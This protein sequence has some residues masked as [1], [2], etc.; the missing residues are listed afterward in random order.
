MDDAIM[1]AIYG[2]RGMGKSS[3]AKQMMANY[4]RAVVLD[5]QGEFAY[6]PGFKSVAWADIP[7]AINQPKFNLSYKPKRGAAP[8][9]LHHI[10]DLL[11][12]HQQP[13]NE[14][15]AKGRPGK[16]PQKQIL[17]MVEEMSLSY[18]SEKLPA[19]LWGMTEMCERGRH[20]GIEVI[21]TTQRP[22]SVS[23]KFRGLAEE[24]FCF[25]LTLENDVN[26]V[27]TY[28]GKEHRQKI[29]DLDKFEY[30]HKTTNGVEQKKT[31][32]P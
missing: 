12:T 30:L 3:L 26:A 20:H 1:R 7:A 4:D 13:Y 18:P 24:T 27:C 5:P 19:E 21:G 29:V 10:C 2:F 8:E 11:L 17:L 9:A 22:A 15:M 14:W 23:T 28:I 16:P 31:Q 6:L 25:K 32:K